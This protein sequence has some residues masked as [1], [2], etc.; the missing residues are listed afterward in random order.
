M[1]AASKTLT[2]DPDVAVPLEMVISSFP[3][4]TIVPQKCNRWARLHRH[5]AHS[6]FIFNIETGVTKLIVQTGNITII[7]RT[8]MISLHTDILPWWRFPSLGPAGDGPAWGL[9]LIRAVSLD[10][11][12][13]LCGND[14]LLLAGLLSRGGSRDQIAC[15]WG[16]Q[17]GRLC[18]EGWGR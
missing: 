11:L 13:L 17:G 8:A 16:A 12:A 9:L 4:V 5:V 10:H 3:G 1:F 15:G 18:G 14:M 6:F 7:I 2:F